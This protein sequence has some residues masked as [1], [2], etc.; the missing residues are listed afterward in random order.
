MG[1]T[2]SNA[3]FG[4]KMGSRKYTF[5]LQKQFEVFAANSR[6]E[7]VF[8][9]AGKCAIAIIKISRDEIVQNKEEIVRNIAFCMCFNDTC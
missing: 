6:N 4:I 1:T 2:V 3:N 5:V 8:P 9:L 7:I